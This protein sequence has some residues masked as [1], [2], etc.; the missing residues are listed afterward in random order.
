M[1]KTLSLV[2]VAFVGLFIS[3]MTGTGCLFYGAT[4]GTFPAM[5]NIYLSFG[6]A[7]MTGMLLSMF[8]FNNKNG[9]RT[10]T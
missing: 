3:M 9:K 7:G 2:L 1:S 6:V 5:V 10:K 8:L 4:F